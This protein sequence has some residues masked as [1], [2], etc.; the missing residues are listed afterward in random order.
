M[1]KNVQVAVIYILTHL[2][3]IFFAYPTDIIASTKEAHW[4]PVTLGFIIHVIVIYTYLKGLSYFKNQ[5]ILQILSNKNKV[6]VWLTLF[7]G[8]LYLFL[9]IVITIRAYAEIISIV[10]LADT[11]IW[12]LMCVLLGIPVFMVIHGGVRALLRVGLLLAVLFLPPML[13]V[14]IST[15]QNIDLH[16]L[17]PLIPSSR[18]DLFAFL[19]HFS[20]YKSLFAFAG[21]FLFLGFIPSYITFKPKTIYISSIILLLFFLLSVYI[22]ILTL[23]EETAK[24]LAFPFIFTI[25]TIEINW[26][27]FDRIT[28]FF[29]LS[30]IAFV[31]LFVAMTLWQIACLMRCRVKKMKYPYLLTAIAIVVL[32]VCLFIPDWESVELL[33]QWN[34]IL[35]FYVALVVPIVIFF[36][37]YRYHQ[38]SQR[39]LT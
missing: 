4:I 15:F 23:G 17:F 38:T 1:M 25:D 36:F 29:L 33:L 32:L 12:I 27:M 24:Q 28:I 14:M 34:S 2:G 22:P 9:V 19:T 7:P 13:F 31:I 26:L 18:T 6:I 35:R 30:Q 21:G 10:F 11:P 16:Y 20:F 39:K 5:N 3:L 8:L 37:G